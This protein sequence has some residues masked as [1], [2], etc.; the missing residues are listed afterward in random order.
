MPKEIFQSLDFYLS[1]FSQFWFKM[2]LSNINNEF[3]FSQKN[4]KFIIFSILLKIPYD[5]SPSLSPSPPPK[6]IR[7]EQQSSRKIKRVASHE[8][9]VF[10]NQL[11]LDIPQKVAQCKRGLKNPL[12]G[13][14]GG[15]NDPV[16]WLH[17]DPRNSWLI[18]IEKQPRV[19]PG[20]CS[21]GGLGLVRGLR[22]PHGDVCT[23]I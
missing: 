21:C 1:N 19:R 13:P 8:R 23:T 5:Y 15:H 6:N 3:C 14:P 9:V 10:S 16:P 20:A 22:K 18:S 4:I 2:L 11:K 17:P 7:N 12:R